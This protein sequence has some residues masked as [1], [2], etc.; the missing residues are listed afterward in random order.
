[1]SRTVLSCHE[2]YCPAGTGGGGGRR[3]GG[4]GGGGRSYIISINRV[5]N[6]KH[7]AVSEV[8]AYFGAKE[9]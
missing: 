1:M 6:S 8:D 3:G 7:K 9:T 2:V 5:Y 4:G